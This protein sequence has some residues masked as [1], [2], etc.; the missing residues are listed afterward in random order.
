MAGV[1]N[2][3]IIIETEVSRAVRGLG[4]T[5]KGLKDNAVAAKVAAQALR[6]MNVAATQARGIQR[7]TS[8]V[9][10]ASVAFGQLATSHQRVAFLANPSAQAAAFGTMVTG[11][12]TM[13]RSAAANAIKVTT[14]SKAVAFMN[15]NVG[16]LGL[17]LGG[18]A[19]VG[20][21]A[22]FG[23]SSV[24]AF[25]DVE[26][27]MA[28]VLTLAE[29]T[30]E[31]IE[32]MEKST[33]GL[34]REFGVTAQAI[35]ESRFDV[36][37]SGFEEVNEQTRI[38]T[39]SIK[40]AKTANASF[41]TS[42]ET[43]TSV[44]AAF[45]FDASQTEVVMDKLKA[46]GD[47][48]KGTFEAL[49]PAIAVV[50]PAAVETGKSLDE[51]IASL[52]ALTLAGIKEDQAARLLSS[53]FIQ[54]IKPE[55][56]R[57]IKEAG[58]N[59][60]FDKIKTLELIDVIKA[61]PTEKADE[62]FEILGRQEAFRGIS[63][64]ARDLDGLKE[65]IEEVGD[66]TGLVAREMAEAMSNPQ[67]KLDKLAQT[68]L[69]MKE[70]VGEA[71]IGSGEQLGV[72]E[73]IIDGIGA[74]VIFVVRTFEFFGKALATSFALLLGDT[75]TATEGI[76][77]LFNVLGVDIE[78]IWENTVARVSTIISV[79]GRAV[80]LVKEGEW[81]AAGK[82]AATAFAE[83][84]MQGPQLP[85]LVPT[86]GLVGP[87][88][89][90]APPETV[91]ALTEPQRQAN[92][93]LLQLRG[94]DL[95]AF[96][97]NLDIELEAA[98][99]QGVARTTLARIRSLEIA[100][101]SK[102]AADKERADAAQ[103]ALDVATFEG[104]RAE[105]FRIGLNNKVEALR[106]AGADELAIANGV[107]LSQTE[108]EL[109]E[110]RRREAAEEAARQ[111]RKEKFLEDSNFMQEA[112]VN[113]VERF[114]SARDVLVAGATDM[115]NAFSGGLAN[116]ITGVFDALGKGE[117][118]DFKKLLAGMLKS[119]G[120]AAIATGTFAILAGTIATIAPGIGAAAG[121]APG[122]GPAVAAAGVALVAFGGG[123]VA[124]AGALS[125]GGS[126]TSGAPGGQQAAQGGGFAQNIGQG[127]R[128][129]APAGGNITFNIQGI[130]SDADL[131]DTLEN[132]IMPK[133]EEI[134]GRG[135]SKFVINEG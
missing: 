59:L 48:A 126:K 54:L 50:A 52:S 105:V 3:K 122:T 94:Q 71:V 62:L 35:S 128:G 93:R 97:A 135:A 118:I 16:K 53:S 32:A 79:L 26:N 87:T 80:G 23:T 116:A 109:S 130:L 24:K 115:L 123:L 129:R 100:K 10:Q 46:G 40:L 9:R 58:L 78:E 67:V 103:L 2:A 134:T 101:F 133:M 33:E 5:E 107:Q 12:N 65:K 27:A 86:V 96:K 92:I 18:A 15:T 74:A 55:T 113:F 28:P 37:S 106:K 43:L 38:L 25:A 104:D 110:I 68:W 60:D 90:T 57:R 69:L 29:F 117:K 19:V 99:E 49:G 66:S 112:L 21:I 20:G 75:E 34:R 114:Q 77:E 131:N 102:D 111:L 119:I 30:T 47:I 132:K 7:V 61:L 76:K 121:I 84:Q 45:N 125:K 70:N 95:A 72:L 31:Q 22:R 36:I 88:R 42:T 44:L 1:A 13:G 41:T 98:R 89:P 124:A 120:T 17:A 6:Q 8:Q 14:L 85:T 127:A 4:Q 64:L 108:F 11:M 91:E 83:G 39:A 73:D 81:E 63:V 56:L 51:V 82:L